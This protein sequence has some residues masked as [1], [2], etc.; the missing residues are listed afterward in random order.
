MKLRCPVC[1][2]ANS[3]EAYTE[4]A[5]Q[6]ELLALLGQ[7]SQLFWPMASYLGCFR[8]PSRDL[9]ASRALKLAREVLALIADQSALA[10]AL[11]ETVEAMRGKREAGDVRPLKNHNYLKRVLESTL[12]IPGTSLQIPSGTPARRGR[13]SA[14][15]VAE[16]VL[17]EW[18]GNDWLRIEISNGL[19]ALLALPLYKSPDPQTIDRT[20]SLWEMELRKGRIILVEEIDRLRVQKGFASLLSAVKERFPEPSVLRDLMPRRPEQRKMEAPPISD[21]DREVGLGILRSFTDQPGGTK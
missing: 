5:A 12:A 18:T 6:R 1:H 3:L 13:K 7:H 11:S 9:S 20:A 21:E 17:Q 10:V 4:D 16:A 2:S 8:S 15:L 19:L 14:G